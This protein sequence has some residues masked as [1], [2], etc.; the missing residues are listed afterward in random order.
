MEKIYLFLGKEELIIKNKIEEIINSAK[1]GAFNITRYDMSEANIGEVLNDAVT[2]PFMSRK[3]VVIITNPVFLTTAKT[4]VNINGLLNYIDNPAESTVLI[5]NATGLELDKR[6]SV[7]K[8][9]K[10]KAEVSNTK[11]LSEI[12]MKGWLMRQFEI[13]NIH[14]ESNAVELFFE[15]VG[16]DLLRAKQEVT[17]LLSYIGQRTEVTIH[18]V[19]SVVSKNGISSVFDL[20]AA[21]IK[22]DKTKIM[23]VYFDLIKNGT[24]QI[25]LI[26]LI[27]NSVKNIYSTLELLALGCRQTE[28]AEK[29]HVSS[30][31]AYYMM[32][33][34]ESF[35][36]SA[37]EDIIIKIGDLDYNIK[38][39]KVDKNSAMEMFLFGL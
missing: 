25:Q 27:F 16:P 39:G 14:I 7:V 34:A 9:L 31:R 30:G 19:A 23:N 1:P 2:L 36:I 15:Y 22:K 28:I 24:E 11:N 20:T 38:I 33:D 29:L 6:K 26:G 13:H 10:Q 3:K 4:D 17:K 5:I 21:I 18:D 8:A 32:K 12:E 37:V 35:E